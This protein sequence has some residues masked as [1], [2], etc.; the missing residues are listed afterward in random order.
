MVHSPLN[1]GVVGAGYF[2]QL[3]HRAWQRCTQASLA[4]IADPKTDIRIPDGI[5]HFSSLTDMME[6]LDL[7][8]M[9]IASPPASHLQSIEQ[10]LAAGI[11]KIICQKPF[12]TNIEEARQA[13]AAAADH[14]AC[15][16]IH[17]NFRFQPWYRFLKQALSEHRFG[18]IYQFHFALRPGDGRGE[19]AYLSRQPYFQKMPRFLVQETAVH[20]LDTF[21]FLFGKPTAL[22]ADLRQLNP[23]LAGE[24]AGHIILSFGQKMRAIFDGNRL[25]DHLTNQ[26]RL[27]MGEARM[28]TE[29]G[30]VSLDGNGKITLRPHHQQD[31]TT[32]LPAFIPP[33]DA[34]IFGGDCVYH[35]CQHAVDAWIASNTPENSAAEYLSILDYAELCYASAK[36]GKRITLQTVQEGSKDE[37]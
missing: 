6:K 32:L 3:H 14:D 20:F 31:I 10:A 19:D 4:G 29:A 13:V 34:D 35:L 16:I 2:A 37:Q 12:C 25:S 24:D 27:T 36:T 7:D 17:E 18:E 11:K 1:I 22:F 26:P 5:A 15:L 9:D 30:I 28:D 23:V 8:I 21:C 33:Q